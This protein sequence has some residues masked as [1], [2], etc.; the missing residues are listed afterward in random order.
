MIFIWFE[1]SYMEEIIIC[2]TI[3]IL[4]GWFD[5][6][7]YKTKLW[8]NR[9]SLACLFLMLICLGA[10][11]GCDSNLLAQIETL[12]KQAFVL[13]GSTIIGTMVMFYIIIKLFARDFDEE[14][15]EER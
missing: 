15:G 9:A 11:I 12:G 8:L 10:K 4:L 1:G 3:G 6:L 2:I 14:G 5:V 7:S 13:G